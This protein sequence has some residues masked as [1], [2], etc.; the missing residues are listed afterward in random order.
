MK[1]HVD[2][3]STTDLYVAATILA[4]GYKI[5]FLEKIAPNKFA[6]VCSVTPHEGEAIESGYWNNE[7]QVDPRAFTNSLAELKSRMYSPGRKYA[8]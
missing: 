7:L 8:S 2:N 3:Y 1:T 4:C 5:L 6:F